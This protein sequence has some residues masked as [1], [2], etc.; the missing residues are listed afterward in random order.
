MEF[1]STSLSTTSTL[2]E[3]RIENA[4]LWLYEALQHHMH[5]TL[6][7]QSLLEI[8]SYIGAK[9][10]ELDGKF[11]SCIAYMGPLNNNTLFAT[12]NTVNNDGY[13]SFRLN[14]LYVEVF[15][16]TSRFFIFK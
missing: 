2:T 3:T 9:F 11:W 15:K 7:K 4:K 8:C 10:N 14:S 16:R 13:I 5:E 1:F 6:N 12:W